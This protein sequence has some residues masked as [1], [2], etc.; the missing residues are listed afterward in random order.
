MRYL[1]ATR[2][3]LFVGLLC[4]A[5]L[6]G[7]GRR[8]NTTEN[9]GATLADGWQNFRLAE[10]DLAKQDF[11]AALASTEKGPDEYLRAEFGLANVWNLRR[12]GEDP[13]RAKKLYE[14]I[15]KEAP[16]HDLAAWSALALV[17]MQHVVP[18]GHDPDYPAVQAGYAALIKR[19]PNHLA[20]KEATIYQ[21][22]ILIATLETNQLWQAVSNL[23]AY[24]EN[25]AT[26]FRAPAW[27]L[28]AVCYQ[29]LGM[30]RERLNAE[31]KSFE[32]V[33][34]DPAN[35]FNEYAWAY[36]N[37]ATI[38]EFEVGDFDL[39]RQ[40]YK[41]LIKEYPADIR[42]F[43]SKEALARMDRVEDEL[44]AGKQVTR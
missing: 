24:I 28:L 9:P 13:A 2:I 35:P 40:Y 3:A 11:S 36:W 34:I 32:N 25:G 41:Q 42:V 14:Q 26:E 8:A 43:P 15:I 18:V 27:S 31:I 4:A 7:C 37:I 38:A 29:S 21:N 23:T 30:Q 1:A 17:R 10:Y 5:V 44:R 22:A 20:A 39:A 6:T 16:D 33:E 19:Y 12:P